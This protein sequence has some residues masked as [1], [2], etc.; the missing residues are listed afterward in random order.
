MLTNTT[1]CRLGEHED[2][3]LRVQQQ[4]GRVGLCRGA[5]AVNDN[6]CDASPLYK[7]KRGRVFDYWITFF[8]KHGLREMRT[9]AGR[10]ILQCGDDAAAA[11]KGAAGSAAGGSV[12]EPHAGIETRAEDHDG[13][14]VS[15]AGDAAARPR[16]PG[17]PKCRIEVQQDAIWF[18][19]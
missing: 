6:S 2:F 5:T 7:A 3:Y 15:Q 17:K 1:L 12:A 18:N 13:E 11:E 10:Y 14:A 16:K 4:K 19:T 8:Q 9:A